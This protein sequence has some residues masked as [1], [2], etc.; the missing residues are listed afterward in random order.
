MSTQIYEGYKKLWNHV[1]RHLNTTR[2]NGSNLFYGFSD[3]AIANAED[4]RSV[5]R[6][7]YLSNGGA[8]SWGSKKQTSIALSS[9]KAEYMAHLE[10]SREAMW[11]Q[12]LFRELGYIQKEPIL[13]LGDNDGSIA[14]A[15][16]PEFYKRTKHVDIRWHWVR[17]LVNNRLINIVDC[18]DPEQTADILTKQLP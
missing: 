2:P 15:K 6:Y 11:L 9:T 3:A 13:L 18:H 12:N 7:V 1:P 5:S 10:A 4:N 14:M 17:E 8:I 16:N